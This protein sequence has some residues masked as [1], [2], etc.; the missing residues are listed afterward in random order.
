MRGTTER[1]DSL[2]PVG[3]T[4][5]FKVHNQL[6]QILGTVEITTNSVSVF[7]DKEQLYYAPK[8]KINCQRETHYYS[9]YSSSLCNGDECEKFKSNYT[10]REFEST[11]DNLRWS[12]CLAL[13]CPTCHGG[14]W[15]IASSSEPLLPT[16]QRSTTK[17]FNVQSGSYLHLSWLK[18]NMELRSCQMMSHWSWSSSNRAKHNFL[19]SFS[20]G[21]S[22]SSPKPVFRETYGSCSMLLPGRASWRAPGRNPM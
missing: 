1:S 13:R 11:K 10:I 7:C 4:S 21:P 12:A 15:G 5:C 20:L 6:Q 2:S 14:Y 22:D 8:A 9:L 3:E 19:I 16:P 17:C 18:P